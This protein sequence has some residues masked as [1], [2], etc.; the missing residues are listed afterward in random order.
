MLTLTALVLSAA[1]SLRIWRTGPKPASSQLRI[2]CRY[3]VP[4]K[5]WARR[6]LQLPAKLGLYW[7]EWNEGREVVKSLAY[8][9]PILCQDV[10]I[11][12]APKGMIATCVPAENSATAM[13]VPDPEVECKK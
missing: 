2:V 3:D 9:G 6:K 4:S 12:P 1:T 7:L 5:K 13:F 8:F 11:G 10:E